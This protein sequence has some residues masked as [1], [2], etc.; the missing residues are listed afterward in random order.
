MA[1][2]DPASVTLVAAVKTVDP[3]TIL[4]AGV[5]DVGE[6]RVQDLV[7][8]Q[9]ALRDA[10]LR[11]HFIGA[12]QRNKVRKV[13]GAVE[14]IHSVDSIELLETISRI[15]DDK[16]VRQRILIEVNLSGEKAKAGCDERALPALLARA[17]ESAGV[18]VSG[19]M[20]VPAPRWTSVTGAAGE[21]GPEDQARAAFR[22]LFALSKSEGL[23]D[24]SMG[25]TGDFAIAIEEGA[26]IVRVGTAIFGAR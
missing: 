20:T 8:K 18:L 17:R 19:L 14:L 1:G 6:N 4:A 12:L 21:G 11:W 16:G 24:L 23:P 2:R 9:E 7:A 22:R 3:K 15:A 5:Q 26:T 10:D 13:V 25:M